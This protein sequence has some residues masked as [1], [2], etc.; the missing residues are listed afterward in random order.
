MTLHP[1]TTVIRRIEALVRERGSQSA[2]ARAL[3]VST[4]DLSRV[5]LGRDEPG[6]KLL[7]ALGFV[8]VVR[9]ADRTASGV[10]AE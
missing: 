8:R 7:R 2:V 1:R 9:Y 6:P 3:G 10:E 5:L 4:S